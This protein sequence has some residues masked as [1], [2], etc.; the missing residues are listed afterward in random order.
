MGA[1]KGGEDSYN[2]KKGKGPKNVRLSCLKPG[3]GRDI[4]VGYIRHPLLALH[5]E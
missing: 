5:Q 3:L 4:A 2:E 1:Q